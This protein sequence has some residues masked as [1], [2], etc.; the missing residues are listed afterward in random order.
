MLIANMVIVSKTII[1]TAL[2]EKIILF[3]VKD[4]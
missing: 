1:K 3:Y 2:H 4:T